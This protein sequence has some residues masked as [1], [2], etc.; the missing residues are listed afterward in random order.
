[1]R[2]E[3]R[4]TL[5][6]GG[7]SGIGEAAALQ[8][9]R[10]GARVVV[11]DLDLAAAKQTV[12]TIA[13]GGGDALALQVDVADETSVEAMVNAAYER[14]GRL[15]AAMNNAGISDPPRAFTE[16]SGK[17]WQRMI[18]V[19]LTGVFFCMKHE[20]KRMLE[21]ESLGGIRGALCATSSGAGRVPAPGQPHYTAS[22]HGVL[23]IVK[24]AAQEFQAQGIRSNAILPGSTDTPMM[25]RNN[26]P[27]A[28]EQMRRFSPGGEFGVAE[29][30]AAA[31]VWLCSPEARHVNGQSIC[32]DGGQVMV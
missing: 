1:M 32:V 13:G 2:F 27:D 22:K 16:L 6:T 17:H 25:H 3:G 15:D 24:L 9:A 29:E 26:P 14:F 19:N 31:G 11:A 10:E 5:V 12:E 21:Q 28:I 23:G 4:V 18:D 8:F 20:I 7:G 30:V